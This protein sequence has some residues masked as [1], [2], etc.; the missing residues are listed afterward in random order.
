MTAETACPLAA[1]HAIAIRAG[2]IAAGQVWGAAICSA[3]KGVKRP[4]SDRFRGSG[5]VAVVFIQDIVAD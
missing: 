2:K 3:I 4:Y 5:F 1:A